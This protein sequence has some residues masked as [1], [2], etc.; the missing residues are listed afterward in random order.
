MVSKHR[1]PSNITK[2]NNDL[3]DGADM[4]T[5]EDSYQDSYQDSGSDYEDEIFYDKNES[6]FFKSGTQWKPFNSKTS[7]KCER[8][9]TLDDQLLIV[10][11][12]L[13]Q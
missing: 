9:F 10:S 11:S 4:D 13:S 8:I 7:N 5:I 2:I 12:L 6:M 3:N 1:S